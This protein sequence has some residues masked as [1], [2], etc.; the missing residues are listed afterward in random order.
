VLDEA[1]AA[2]DL[3]TYDL[4]QAT[5]RNEFKDCTVITIAHSVSSVR[6]MGLDQGVICEFD[7]PSNLQSTVLPECKDYLQLIVSIDY[8]SF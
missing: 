5:I 1:T 6:V 3:E 2:V 4:I 8:F 7:T